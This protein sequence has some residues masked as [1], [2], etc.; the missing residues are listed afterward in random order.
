MK[1]P[2]LPLEI[3]QLILAKVHD[4]D[5][6][7]P[8]LIA[9]TLVNHTYNLYATPL[10]YNSVSIASPRP[11]GAL[12]K[13]ANEAA[14]VPTK[15]WKLSQIRH[16]DLSSYSTVGSHKAAA[17][18][19]HMVT[20]E[21]LL[22]LLS[23]CVNLRA[24]LVGESLE[25]MLTENVVMSL[26]SCKHLTTVDFVGCS[27]RHFTKA[28]VTLAASLEA[29]SEETV[30]EQQQQIQQQQQQQQAMARQLEEVVFE[31][32]D[33]DQASSSRSSENTS[34]RNS[35]SSVTSNDNSSGSA[36]STIVSSPTSPTF[37]SLPPWLA[38]PDSQPTVTRLPANLTRIGL[39]D[40]P[41][42]PE[43]TVLVPIFSRMTPTLT[44]LDL[45]NTKVTPAVLTTIPTTYLTHLNL[46]KCKGLTCDALVPFLQ[47]CD[48]LEYLNLYADPKAGGSSFCE[49]CILTI[50]ATCPA[51]GTTLRQLDLGGAS[52]G[53]TD[54]VLIAIG[55]YAG[56]KLR[57]LGVAGAKRVTLQGGILP[58]LQTAEIKSSLKYIDLTD[59][60]A[61]AES[62]VVINDLVRK[63]EKTGCVLRCIEVAKAVQDGLPETVG[64]E[65]WIKKSTGRRC[66][67]VRPMAKGESETAEWLLPRKVNVMVARNEAEQSA[68]SKM[69]PMSKYYSFAV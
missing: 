47:R 58:L 33:I 32:K 56:S 43:P 35:M 10:L 65:G 66:A 25:R 55:R 53:I 62:V 6:P 54:R 12:L 61:I 40:C 7:R 18:T 3:H 64:E 38:V 60:P 59:V 22:T 15:A 23:V 63:L 29:R 45:S 2:T 4:F 41:T 26:M 51:V 39:H 50:L 11:F 28:M 20:P 57:S 69:S 67:V 14:E 52:L 8:T 34:R 68:V 30:H 27:G 44:H 46:Q 48:R 24:F 31:N 1:V 37:T 16:L 36:C 13:I 42:L 21:A 5:D 49:D 9:C 19:K 17:D